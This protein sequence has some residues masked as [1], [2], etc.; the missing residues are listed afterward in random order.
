MSSPTGAASTLRRAALCRLDT[1]HP[2][3]AQWSSCCLAERLCRA[4]SAAALYQ[5]VGGEAGHPISGFGVSARR[6]IVA[7][8]EHQVAV[9]KPHRPPARRVYDVMLTDIH[10]LAGAVAEIL[11][12]NTEAFAGGARIHPHRYPDGEPVVCRAAFRGPLV[13]V[14]H[15]QERPHGDKSSTSRTVAMR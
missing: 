1:A 13:G 7:V 8:N 5:Q 10:P 11:H 6:E 2:T 4:P 3:R 14:S 12:D 9:A 15:W